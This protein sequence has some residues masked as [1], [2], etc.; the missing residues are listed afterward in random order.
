MKNL[1]FLKQALIAHRGIHTKYPENSLNAFK[2]AIKQ[3]YI[4]EFDTHLLKD[5]TIV[6]FHD[7]NLKRMTGK[8]KKLKECTYEEI[9]NLKLQNTDNYIPKLE[10]VLSLINGKVPIIVETKYD[11]KTGLLEKELVKRLDKYKG[12]FCV[13]SFNPFSIRWFKKHRPNYIRG[14]LISMKNKTALQKLIHTRIITFLTK[15][16]FISC[17]YKLYNNKNI[18]KH[19]KKR[20]VIAWT[21]KDN[22]K[23]LK[24]KDKFDNLII[25]IDLKK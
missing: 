3:N 9:K 16:D 18:L 14:L 8:N 19:K 15:P 20:T 13:K 25:D 22:E 17:N 11:Q 4:I 7:D 5:N 21:I 23:Y 1:N 12:D 6:V 10:E 24:Y 2:E